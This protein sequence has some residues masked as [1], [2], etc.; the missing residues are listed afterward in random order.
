MWQIDKPRGG[1]GG[2][3]G[4]GSADHVLV[5]FALS[6]YWVIVVCSIVLLSPISK[7]KLHN[8]P[9]LQNVLIIIIL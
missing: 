7:G 5:V 2:G 8:F 6:A 4:K 3:G 9:Q 1:G